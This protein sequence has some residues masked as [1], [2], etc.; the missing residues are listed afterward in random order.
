V[1]DARAVLVALR[2][3]QWRFLG[4]CWGPLALATID[5][6]DPATAPAAALRQLCAAHRRLLA[7]ALR[8]GRWAS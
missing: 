5:G 8:S 2:Y 4:G 1:S 7:S 6:T 3:C